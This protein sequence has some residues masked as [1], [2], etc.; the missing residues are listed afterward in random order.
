[1]KHNS[2]NSTVHSI[3]RLS[4]LD[5]SSS[6]NSLKHKNNHSPLKS[7]KKKFMYYKFFQNLS[8]VDL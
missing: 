8:D 7:N 3:V 6:G 1:M 5:E 4:I 2:T